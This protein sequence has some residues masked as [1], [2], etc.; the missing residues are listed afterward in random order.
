MVIFLL[1]VLF[2]EFFHIQQDIYVMV[3]CDR[4]LGDELI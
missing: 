4:G 3:W 2:N 1:Q